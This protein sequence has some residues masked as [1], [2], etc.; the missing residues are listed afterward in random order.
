[1]GITVDTAKIGIGGSS[2]SGGGSGS[3]GSNT[4]RTIIAAGSVIMVA[5][6]KTVEIN[7]TVPEITGVT[8]PEPTVGRYYTIVDAAHN[9][10]TYPITYTPASG[11]IGGAASYVINVDGGAVTFYWNGVNTEVV[12]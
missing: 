1:M 10:G 12:A 3:G 9:A 7:K 11:L 5:G 8:F 4:L 2:D 6:D